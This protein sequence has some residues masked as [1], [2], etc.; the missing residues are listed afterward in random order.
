MECVGRVEPLLSR[1]IYQLPLNVLFTMSEGYKLW[2][3]CQN[4]PATPLARHRPLAPLAGVH[5][6]PIALGG[7]S[8]GTAWGPITGA[9]TKEEAF[10]LLDAYYEAGGNFVDTAN[11]YH[12][13]QS[14]E[15]IGEWIESRGIREQIVLAT[16]VSLKLSTSAGRLTCVPKYTSNYKRW[17]KIPQQSQY[18]G[19]NMK[20]LHNSLEASLKQLRT[21]YVDILYVHFVSII[22]AEM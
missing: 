7:M 1:L 8:L 2:F 19:N 21:S 9:T 11:M 5:V 6:S 3:S 10:K 13:G 18:T 15:Y 12:D 20:S 4:Q 17:Q 22:T 16:K 14:E